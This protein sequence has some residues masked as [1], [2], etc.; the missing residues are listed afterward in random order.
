MAA[1]DYP[2]EMKGLAVT[3]TRRNFLSGLGA[4]A[5]VSQV[6]LSKPARAQVKLRYANASN[7]GYL[8]NIVMQKFWDEVRNRTAGEIAVETFWGT[9]GGE[10]TLLNGVALGTLDGYHGA[11]T[12]MREFDVFYAANMFRDY[13]QA[14]RVVNGPL[15]TKLQAAL[16]SKYK[17]HML[18]LGRAGSFGLQT[19]ERV[20]SWADLKAKKIRGGQI[21]GIIESIKAIGA[22]AVPMAFNEVYTAL[23]Q[24][25]VDGQVNLNTLILTMKYFE[26]VKCWVRNDFGLGF[27]KVVIS[28]R[29]W[30][31]FKPAQ[32]KMLDELFLEIEAKEWYAPIKERS[33]ADFK[34]WQE[35]HGAD[36][37]VMLDPNEARRLLAP[38]AERLANE[39]FGPGAWKQIQDTA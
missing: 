24:G 23:Q 17:V 31:R 33:V 2:I 26:V 16:E 3:A 36:A 18:G 39:V 37:V 35:I 15:R 1:S 7:A 38:T 25:V 28:Q 5:I 22:N 12:G 34:K 27:D 6:G 11:Y 29:T 14:A 19:K 30:N 32:Q 20:N 4:A 10:Q 9:L 8:G 13:D 21:E